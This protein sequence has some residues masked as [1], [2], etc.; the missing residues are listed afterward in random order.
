VYFEL[1]VGKFYQAK[2]EIATVRSLAAALKLGL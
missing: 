1:L 2:R